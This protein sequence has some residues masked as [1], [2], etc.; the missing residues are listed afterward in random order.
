MGL[1]MAYKNFDPTYN[2]KFSTYAYSYIL[3]EMKK[4]INE[5]NTIKYSKELLSLKYK[6]EKVSILLTQKLMRN[7]TKEEIIN[8]LNINE[9][10]YEEVMLMINPVSLDSKVAE[11]LELYEVISKKELDYS[12]L[13]AL[14][15]EIKKLNKNEKALLNSRY[16]YGETQKEVALEL[17]TNQVDISRQEKKVLMKLKTKL[18]S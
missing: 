13:I 14:K 5:T 8:F 17:K 12:T 2:V 4:V 6:I 15:E 16:L 10:E 18:K 3:G 9:N 11:D 7:P 1:V